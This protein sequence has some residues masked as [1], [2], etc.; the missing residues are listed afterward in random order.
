MAMIMIIF[1]PISAERIGIF[2]TALVY[3]SLLIIITWYLI[4]TR[5]F[6]YL[7][8]LETVSISEALNERTE[9]NEEV[10]SS[11]QTPQII[12]QSI[13]TVVSINDLTNKT[14]IDEGVTENCLTK[15]IGNEEIEE[16]NIISAENS[17]ILDEQTENNTGINEEPPGPVQGD[18]IIVSPDMS[19]DTTES[20]ESV[21]EQ[22][23]NMTNEK[24]QKIID[25]IDKA[26]ARKSSDL[27]L[28]IN[29]FQ[30]ALD[31]TENDE[32]MYLLT[33][34]LLE[35]YKDIG[36][37]GKAVKILSDFIKK[38]TAPD[39]IDQAKGYL[40]YL[41]IMI[42]ELKELG[43]PNLP[44]SAVPRWIRLKVADNFKFL[45]K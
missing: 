19:E 33:M 45:N 29:N 12:N 21:T 3:F 40:V 41:K 37:Y 35:D 20:N 28:A 6:D 16:V 30:A 42:N 27:Q 13:P 2:S 25:L 9:F 24:Q 11:D 23:G 34:E 7:Y 26:F 10:L 32:L 14:T 18:I 43:T 22:D 1:F 44:F 38:T 5:Q 39:N 17:F 4:K 15:T 31:I 36:A 8:K